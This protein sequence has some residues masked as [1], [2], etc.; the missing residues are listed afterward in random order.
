MVRCIAS[1]VTTRAIPPFFLVG[2][3]RSGT[4]L[5]RE[6]LNVSPDIWMSDGESHFIPKYTRRV[7]RFGDLQDRDNF[8][9]LTDALRGTRVF[10]HWKRR[11]INL[12]TAEWYDACPRHDWPGVIEGLFRCIHRYEIPNPRV[13]FDQIV[14]GDKTPVYMREIPLLAELFPH[15]RFVHILRDPRDCCLSTETAWGNAPV[16]TAA[17]WA[18]RTRR[19][20]A[21]GQALGPGRYLELRYEDLTVDVRKELGRVFDFLGVPTPADAG[22]LFRV[23][24]NLGTAK[25]QTQVVAGNAAKWKQKM[26]P[27]LRRTIEGLTGDLLET[28]R[29]EREY[30]ELPVRTLPAAELLAYRLRD[31]WFQLRF[32]RK[33]LGSWSA[34]VRFLMAR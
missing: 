11:G 10:W 1:P 19:C 12:D 15:A 34:A 28:Y 22:K 32:R 14:W 33:E 23:P 8:R 5:L 30:P 17:E 29:Y 20:R 31:A 13:P 26:A 3:P 6:L 7:A 2:N 24:E 21:A 18:D 25:G 9:R 27:D 16:R 4:K